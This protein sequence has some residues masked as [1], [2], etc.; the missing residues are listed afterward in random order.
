MKDVK[1]TLKDM[2]KCFGAY[3]VRRLRLGKATLMLWRGSSPSNIWVE[4][5]TGKWLWHSSD[6]DRGVSLSSFE[7]VKES[8]DKITPSAVHSQGGQPFLTVYKLKPAYML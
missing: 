7:V 2:R 3:A 8:D 1:E 4:G 5:R 6:D